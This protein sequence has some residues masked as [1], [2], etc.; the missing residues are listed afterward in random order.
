MG[1][2]SCSVFNEGCSEAALKVDMPVQVMYMPVTGP[3][4]EQGFA[5][6]PMPQPMAYPVQGMPGAAPPPM[7]F[8]QGPNGY[9]MPVAMS[10]P[11]ADPSGDS[12]RS[13][14]PFDS[15]PE[16]SAPA[17]GQ[18]QPHSQLPPLPKATSNASL[19]GALQP[20][21]TLPDSATGVLTLIFAVP[22]PGPTHP[23]SFQTQNSCW[24]CGA[25]GRGEAGFT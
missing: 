20:G 13:N 2:Q 11:T 9:Y 14:N 25:C 21:Q 4:G 5:P 18:W 7:Q 22:A 23:R 1:A 6:V 24:S 3:N 12:T 8:V 16:L 19:L 10:A 17:A 15:A